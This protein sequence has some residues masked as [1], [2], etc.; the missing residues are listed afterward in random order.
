MVVTLA[1]TTNLKKCN[2][3]QNSALRIITG[4]A[5]STPITAMQLQTGKVVFFIDF[6]ASISA[7][8]SNTL[9]DYLNTIQC[10]VPSHVGIPGNERADQKAKQGAES[11]QS[12]VPLTLRSAKINSKL[13]YP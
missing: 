2:F 7:L 5:K 1:S 8:S 12:K 10:Q 9:T 13:V 11:S 6:Q 3:V 4:G